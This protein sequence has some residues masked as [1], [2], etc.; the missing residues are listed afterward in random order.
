MLC[1]RRA[2]ELAAITGALREAPCP[3]CVKRWAEFDWTDP[4]VECGAH[5]SANTTKCACCFKYNKKC[6]V[7]PH[8]ARAAAAELR[9]LFVPAKRDRNQKAI[10]AAQVAATQALKKRAASG[11]A[12]ADE[13]LARERDARRVARTQAVAAWA[14]ARVAVAA[15]KSLTD[16]ARA[17]IVAALGSPPS[18][19][20]KL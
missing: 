6:G 12:A 16:E 13:Q 7:V 4:V 2:R 9:A 5:T 11:D 19:E 3:E 14:Q 18:F 10:E 20:E 15:S 8:H 1:V 17:E